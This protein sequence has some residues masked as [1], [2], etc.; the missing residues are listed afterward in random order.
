M[1][2]F[3]KSDIVNASLM[4]ARAIVSYTSKIENASSGV[5]KLK[6]Q[7]YINGYK[8]LSELCRDALAPAPE[9]SEP[10]LTSLLI[11]LSEDASALAGY[12]NQR[13][14]VLKKDYHFTD[15]GQ[16]YRIVGVQLLA[17]NADNLSAEAILAAER[18]MMLHIVREDAQDLKVSWILP[19]AD[20]EIID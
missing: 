20:V 1:S 10:D 7:G 2:D 13:C 12:Y 6:F 5:D 19:L 18:Q 3:A 14:R 17:T 15:P 8:L 16:V 11:G 4:C 9:S